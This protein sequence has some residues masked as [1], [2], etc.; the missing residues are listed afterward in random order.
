MADI[1]K[2]RQLFREAGL[3][4]PTIPEELATRLTEQGEWLFSTREIDVWPYDLQHYV[5]EFLLHNVDKRGG[6]HVED[7]AIL[8]HSGHGANSYA[9]Q[10]YLVHGVLGLFLHLGWGGA[11]MDV[12]RSTT[13]IHDCFSLTDRIVMAVSTV[14]KLQQGERLT[15][16]GSD[17]YG[18]YWLPPGKSRWGADEDSKRPVK[19]LTDV[20]RWLGQ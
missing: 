15:I 17:F 16:V 11:Y 20:L 9:L 8:S 19:V 6:R 4:F 1:E 12:E 3:A 5:F 2:A 7:Y 10:Y 13:Q 18:S 14:G